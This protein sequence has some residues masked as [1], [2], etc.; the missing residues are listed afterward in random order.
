M[1]MS[2]DIIVQSVMVGLVFASFVTWTVWL[3]KN[4]EL[5]TAMW[6]LRRAMTTIG[7]ERSL[8]E[9]HLHLRRS[10][11]IRGD[12]HRPPCG[13]PQRRERLL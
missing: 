4:I 5:W 3:A 6:R 2:A 8:A 13:R 11:G 10:S 9:A 1:F 7:A 12:D